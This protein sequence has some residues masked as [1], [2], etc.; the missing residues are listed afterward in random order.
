[1]RDRL[2]SIVL[3]VFVSSVYFATSAGLT[4]SNDG[5]HYALLR[6]MV[7]DHTFEIAN[8][9]AFAEG[10]DLAIRG[11]HIYSDRPPGTALLGAPFYLIGRILPRPIAPI[12]TRHDEGNPQIVYLMVLPALAGAGAV[13]LAYLIARG[14]GLSTY[15][16][17]TASL[18]FAFASTNWKYGSVLFSHG[19]SALLI[20]GGV[21]LAL[22][23]TRARRLTWPLALLLGLDLGL[24]VTV[25]YSN[26]IFTSVILLYIALHLIAR[27]GT[28]RHAPTHSPLSI[29][30]ERVGG[31]ARWLA[32]LALALGLALPLGYLAWYN[33][34]NFG[35]PLITSYKYA[36]N[37]PWAASF[38]TTFD[39][40]LKQGLS[41]MLWFG[42]DARG[43]DNQGIFLLMP[44][45]LAALP[46]VWLYFK[47]NWREAALTV[48]L[49]LGYL[50][51][52]AKHHTFSGFTFDGRYLTPFLGLWFVPLAFVVEA[53][54]EW[55]G[56]PTAKALTALLLYGL[57]FLSARNIMAHI[58]FSY[59]YHLEPGLLLRRSA[60]PENWRYI[61]GSIFV[62]VRNV[63][64]LWLIEGMALGAII[65]LREG[66]VRR[67]RLASAGKPSTSENQGTP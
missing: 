9:M 12:P 45:T 50:L 23:I 6:A 58:A 46:G 40:P 35:G 13:L 21:G 59:N 61:L 57:I 54:Y 39:V 3:F 62:N 22:N 49:F 34:V 16:A 8:F 18:A 51:L 1:V 53:F 55:R 5:S 31:E 41:G 60:H 28:A 7:D 42:V 52:F 48:G 65:A 4:S 15:A 43:E 19:V 66:L 17:L 11:D 30:G 38:R 36:I 44:I 25:E 56:R 33:T 47:K 67:L 26:A 24:S 37:Y 32:G 64:L 14:Y 29:H 20:L 10:N 2:L 63:P 27:R